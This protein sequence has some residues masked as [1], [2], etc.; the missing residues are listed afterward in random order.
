MQGPALVP[1]GTSVYS[2][3]TVN[4]HGLGTWVQAALDDLIHSD[5][6]YMVWTLIGNR[7]QGTHTLA[8]FS[9]TLAGAWGAGC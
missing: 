1:N 9:N 3:L 5:S 7:T 6:D 2:E 4:H 8:H